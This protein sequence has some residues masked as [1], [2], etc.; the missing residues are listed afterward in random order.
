VSASYKASYSYARAAL[1]DA[2]V[3]LR[4]PLPPTLAGQSRRVIEAGQMFAVC[5]LLSEADAWRAR[6]REER[7]S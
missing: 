7:A 5:A 1:R 3:W 4:A 6:A 2:R